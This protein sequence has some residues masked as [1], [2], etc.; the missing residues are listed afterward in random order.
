MASDLLKIV[1]QGEPATMKDLM[2]R[3]HR[4]ALSDAEIQ[5]GRQWKSRLRRA[6]MTS[7]YSEY[8]DDSVQPLAYLRNVFWFGPRGLEA[9]GRK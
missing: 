7:D 6:W 5:G 1:N 3:E 4:H 8:A 9:W 2:T